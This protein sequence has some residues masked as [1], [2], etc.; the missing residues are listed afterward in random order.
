MARRAIKLTDVPAAGTDLEDYVASLFQSSGYYVE[1]S[2]VERDPDDVLELD[3]VATHYTNQ[4]PESILVEAKGGKWGYTDIFKVCGWMHYLNQTRGAFFVTKD[5]SK[6]LERVKARVAQMGIKLVQL[7]DFTRAVATFEA[8]ELG[9]PANDSLV[10]LWRFSSMVERTLIR[11]IHEASKKEPKADGPSE[12]LRY[13]RLVNDGVFFTETYVETLD[14]LYDAYK[15]H[16]KLTLATALE[17]DGHPYDP[18]PPATNNSLIGEALREGKHDLLQASLY[19]EH[20]AR[21]A[22]LRAAVNLC[23]MNPDGYEKSLEPGS[24]EWMT[25]YCLPRTF[26]DAMEWLRGQ[27]HFHLYALFWQQFLWGWGGFYLRHMRDAEFEWMSRYSGIPVDEIPNA[28]TAFDRF[29]PMGQ[30]G[31]TLESDYHD[32]ASIKMMPMAFQGIGAHQRRQEY[33]DPDLTK[34]RGTGYTAV[35]MGRW[36]NCTVDFLG[37]T[38]IEEKASD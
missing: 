35:N 31:W 38:E 34:I 14:L 5:Q 8:A 25:Y 21:L 37:G 2:L 36:I 17:M 1:K 20:R 4:L 27:P 12:I 9:S 29:F 22:I 26:I 24:L 18:D 16:P 19:T 28:L 32:I 11:T 30:G 3:I 15:S 33:D 10:L 6:D 7:D 23:C 13:H